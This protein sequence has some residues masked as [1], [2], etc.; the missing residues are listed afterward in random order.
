MRIILF[1]LFILIT[2]QSF[3]QTKKDKITLLNYQKDSLESLLFKTRES[4]IIELEKMKDAKALVELKIKELTFLNEKLIYDNTTVQNQIINLKQ[5][6]DSINQ[7]KF[8]LLLSPLVESTENEGCIMNLL[9]NKYKIILPFRENVDNYSNVDILPIGW[10]Q[11][12]VFAYYWISN[13]VCGLCWVGLSFFDYNTGKALASYDYDI[14]DIEEYQDKERSICTKIIN[15]TQE[16]FT[17]FGITPISDMKLFYIKNIE[18]GDLILENKK[19]VVQKLDG[20]GYLILTE[21]S[22][23]ESRTLFEKKLNTIYV[24]DYGHWCTDDL[25]INGCFYNPLNKKQLIIHLFYIVPCG[26]ENEDEYHD[27]FVP[28]PL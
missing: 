18:E 16:G 19:I 2:V 1:I 22:G 3:A 12:G 26:F 5:Q 6:L 13:S 27:F 23:N 8:G 14:Q 4:Y 24:E 20:K 11:K 28:I 17:K 9:R 10:S 7:L 15:D 21:K 25:I